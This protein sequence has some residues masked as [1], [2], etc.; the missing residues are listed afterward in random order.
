VAKKTETIENP[1]E[2]EDNHCFEGKRTKVGPLKTTK[3]GKGSKISVFDTVTGSQ[4]QWKWTKKEL[5]KHERGANGKKKGAFIN[6]AG[7]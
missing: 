6:R 7:G 3:K 2:K 5:F 4:M 1:P